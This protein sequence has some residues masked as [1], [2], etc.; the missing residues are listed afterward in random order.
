MH[1]LIAKFFDEIEQFKIET[2]V[3]SFVSGVV[4]GL[5]PS[6]TGDCVYLMKIRSTDRGKGLASETLAAICDIA[7]QFAI[8]L[9]LEVEESDGMSVSQLAEWYWRF[10]FRG[11]TSEMIRKPNESN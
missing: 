10:G 7:D 6:K 3:Y 5:R 1:D 11:T 4:V 9:F 8:D 2:N